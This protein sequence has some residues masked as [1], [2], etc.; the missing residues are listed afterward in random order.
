M[1]LPQD[2]S[3]EEQREMFRNCRAALL[4]EQEVRGVTPPALPDK[5]V[6]VMQEQVSFIMAESI[7]NAPLLSLEDGFRR[8]AFVEGWF[9]RFGTTVREK[10]GDIEPAETRRAKLLECQSVIWDIMKVQIDLLLQQRAQAFPPI[11]PHPGFE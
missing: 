8:G 6:D 7:F 4:V 1:P 11:I 9:L 2:Y 5:L 3:P 10:L